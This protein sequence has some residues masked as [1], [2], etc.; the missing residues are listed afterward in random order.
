[1]SIMRF[2]RLALVLITGLF[3][4]VSPPASAQVYGPQDG[5]TFEAWLAGVRSEA[6]A[7]GVPAGVVDAAL[8]DVTFDPE[9]LERDRNQPEFVRT[10]WDYLGNAVSDTRVSRG[11]EMLRTHGAL[12]DRLEAQYGVPGRYIVAIWGAESNFGDYQGDYEVIQSIAARAYLRRERDG[13]R[14]QLIDA[15]RVLA[16]GV[17][18]HQLVGSWAGAMGQPQFMPTAWLQFA[19]D[20]DQNGFADIWNSEADVFASIANYLAANGWERGER[21]G[22]EVRLPPGFPYEQATLDVQRTVSQWASMGV[23]LPNGA[24]LPAAD[25]PASIVLPAGHQG[26]AFLVYNNF[27]TILRYN[28]SIYYGLV[29]GHLADRFIGGEAL[30]AQAPPGQRALRYEEI[31]EIQELLARLGFDP[32]PADGIPG[33]RTIGAIRD[34]QRAIG[35][36]ADGHYSPDLLQSLRQR[37]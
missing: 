23:S 25:L 1:M 15:L 5:V 34:F 8:R 18:E 26:A 24:P 10:F 14:S 19:V 29:I 12:L 6:I 27:R 28:Q 37:L 33:S 31:R 3:L 22:R 9:I 36:P 4:G 16:R 35:V 2:P 20:Y 21:W 32:G 7:G 17:P 30:Y 13:F 11:T